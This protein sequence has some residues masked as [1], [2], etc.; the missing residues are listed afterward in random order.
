MNLGE[1][2]TSGKNPKIQS[3][4]KLLADSKERRRTNLFAVEGAREISRALEADYTLVNIYK[5]SDKISADG[6]KLLATEPCRALSG[7][8]HFTVDSELFARIVVRAGSDGL[9]GVFRQKPLATSIP[10]PRPRSPSLELDPLY[11][12]LQGIEKP[13]NIGALLRSADGAGV[14]GV[15]ILVDSE[16][17]IDLYNPHIIRSSVGAVFGLNIVSIPMRMLKSECQ[18]NKLQ[19]LAA[20]LTPRAVTPYEIQLSQPTVLMLGCE[21]HGLPE[22]LISSADQ[23][24]MLPMMGIAD[25]LNVSVAGGILLYE[26]R[27]Q[28]KQVK[29]LNI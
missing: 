5:A 23:V 9:V 18:A 10:P 17:E 13:G 19:L 24:V 20:A 3:L 25:S 22:Q 29:S 26:A 27:R 4:K 28:M 6:Q 7:R 2:L 15:I 1:I 11:L 12:A 8:D 16:G 21:A 14:D